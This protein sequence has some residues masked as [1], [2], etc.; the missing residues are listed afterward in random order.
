MSAAAVPLAGLDLEGPG[1]APVE[2][3][4]SGLLVFIT[5]ARRRSTCDLSGAGGRV[6]GSGGIPAVQGDDVGV[7]QR[8]AD[9]IGNVLDCDL[10][11]EVR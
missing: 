4:G 11:A 2:D 9:R 6:W 5:P 10:G 3:K 8:V 1:Q 7:G